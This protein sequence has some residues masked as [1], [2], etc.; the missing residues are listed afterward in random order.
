MKLSE[1]S[2]TPKGVNP[3]AK[4]PI[5]KSDNSNGADMTDEVIKMSEEMDKK[6]KTYMEEKGCDRKTAEE[7]LMKSFE[8]VA[9]LKAE[10][11]RLRKGFLDEGYIIKADTIEKKA[12]EEFIEVEG[13]KINKADIPAPILKRLEEADAERT[14]AA[15]VAK[16]KETLPNFDQTVAVKIM[17]FD[18]EDDI[19]Q[20]LLAADKFFADMTDEIGKNDHKGDLSDPSEKMNELVAKYAQDHNVT[21]AQA[22]AQVAKTEVGKSL[23]K[24]IYKEKE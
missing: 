5:F 19:L 14:Q 13:E 11:E 3:L 12:P 23:V 1:L 9:T 18:L 6:I 22:Y 17:K 8:D 7:A 21:Q 24:A 20:V 2:L 16:A 15:L 4:A 10:N